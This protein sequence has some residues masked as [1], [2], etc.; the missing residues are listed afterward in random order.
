[1]LRMIWLG[2]LLEGEVEAALAALADGLGERAPR[3]SIL[4]V[5]AVPET[6]TVLPR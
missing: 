4:P 6:S 5:P 1:M 3:C 2:R